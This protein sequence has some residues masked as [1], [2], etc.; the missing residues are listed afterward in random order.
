MRYLVACD[1][2]WGPII[3]AHDVPTT[4]C[5]GYSGSGESPYFHSLLKTIIHQQLGIKAAK[6]IEGRVM[7][8]L[9]LKPGAFATPT[10]VSRAKWSTRSEGGKQ[11]VTLNGAVP[12]LS[13]QKAAYIQSL[14]ASFSSGGGLCGVNLDSLSDADLCEKLTQVKGIGQWSSEM[15]LMFRMRRQ[16]VFSPGDLILRQG[17]AQFVG[18]P[19]DAF[20][21]TNKKTFAAASEIAAN[22]SPYRSLASAYLW[23]SKDSRSASSG[24]EKL[25]K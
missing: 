24:V 20:R 2:R 8:A 3:S 17:T 1:E 25:K 18:K 21:K 6:T 4:F 23:K 22:W 10:A 5:A 15:F 16:D 9:K 19:K 7:T 11:K 12:G 13:H 14:A